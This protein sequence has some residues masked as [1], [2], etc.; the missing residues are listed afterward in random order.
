MLPR[1]RRE[2]GSVSV[3]KNVPGL[4]SRLISPVICDASAVDGKSASMS[5]NATGPQR[6]PRA[7][8]AGE[9]RLVPASLLGSAVRAPE[10][11]GAPRSEA[12][13]HP[14]E[15]G[16][17]AQAA[18]L[19]DCQAAQPA[20]RSGTKHAHRHGALDAGL[21]QP[22]TGAVAANHDANGCLFAG[23]DSIRA[24]DGGAGAEGGH[25]IAAGSGTLDLREGAAASQRTR[26]G[27][28]QPCAEPATAGRSGD[29]KSV[30]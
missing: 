4:L 11:A 5:S 21:R 2:R 15:P 28:G 9:D 6:S 20:S 22:G 18:R 25:L 3:L 16:G 29:R 27:A 17:S 8:A 14:G 24:A 12:G 7:E 23:V 1:R 10:P 19:R 30:V 13:Q 26:G